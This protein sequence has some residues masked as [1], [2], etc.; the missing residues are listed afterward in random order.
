MQGWIKLHR[1]LLEW[2][3]YDDHNATRLFIHLVLMANHE[4]RKWQGVLIKRGELITS[5][6]KLSKQ[7]GLSI[8]NI[9]TSLKHLKSTQALTQ[10]RHTKYTHL[11]IY[12]W[13]KY[14]QSDTTGDKEV[15]RSRHGGD[16]K[17]EYKNDKNI[18]KYIESFNKLFFTKY[19]ETSGR[20]KKLALRLKEYPLKEILKA[21]DN[22]A[23][24]EFHRG[25]NNHGWKADPDFLIRSEEQV[26]KWINYQ[27]K[28]KKPKVINKQLKELYERLDKK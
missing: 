2:E 7:T 26:D 20:T 3:W 16:N 1:Q 9:R 19:K 28:K 8:R 23:S 18:R 22:L 11:S 10:Y 24:S 14:Q 15:T 17:Q 25:K 13:G 12:N 4:D 6:S 5:L 21:L 27:G